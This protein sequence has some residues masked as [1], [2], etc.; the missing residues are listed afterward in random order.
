[1]RAP[2][3][4]QAVDDKQ[5]TTHPSNSSLGYSEDIFSA[6]TVPTVPDIRKI[7]GVASNALQMLEAATL[8]IRG[9]EEKSAFGAMAA[10]P[11]AMPSVAGEWLRSLVGE[12]R[13][14]KLSIIQFDP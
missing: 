12:L 4:E 11:T 7:H 1:M 14:R 10:N 9:Q 8:P 3:E 6:R 13:I 5:T 2:D